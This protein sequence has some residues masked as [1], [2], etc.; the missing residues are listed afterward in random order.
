MIFLSITGL[1]RT[2]LILIGL[3]VVVRFLGQ[4]M[5]A[6]RNLAEE[7]ELKERERKFKVEKEQ[8]QKNLGKTSILNDRVD[9]SNVSD[10]DFEEI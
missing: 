6:K 1:V 3:F 2:L 10:V 9:S 7:S 4:L 5:I 8:K